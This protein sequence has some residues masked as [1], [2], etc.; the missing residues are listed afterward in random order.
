MTTHRFVYVLVAAALTASIGCNRDN[1]TGP[2]LSATPVPPAPTPTPV[3]GDIAGSWIG[4]ATTPGGGGCG[5]FD[6]N[7]TFQQSGQNV[8][9]TLNAIGGPCGF[10]NQAFQGTLVGSALSGT[11]SGAD[12]RATVKGTLSG[13][14]LTLKVRGLYIDTPE[15]DMNLHR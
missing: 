4:S 12:G 15:V 11:S 1:I 2:P 6:A 10:T 7:A 3:P 9:G 8:T 5:K 13:A 14:G